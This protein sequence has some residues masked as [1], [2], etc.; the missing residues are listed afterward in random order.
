MTHTVILVQGWESLSQVC[1]FRNDYFLVFFELNILKNSLEFVLKVSHFLKNKGTTFCRLK[2]SLFLLLKVQF[3]VLLVLFFLDQCFDVELGFVFDLKDFLQEQVAF[4]FLFIVDLGSN[5]VRAL[6]LD[7]ASSHIDYIEFLHSLS[8]VP[9]C[10]RRLLACL[11]E[12][13]FHLEL[14]LHLVILLAKVDPLLSLRSLI[15]LE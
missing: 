7:R 3:H 5:L 11:S 13:M 6:D 14:T 8:H 2:Q 15:G 9:A 4:L 12:P 10:G 1:A